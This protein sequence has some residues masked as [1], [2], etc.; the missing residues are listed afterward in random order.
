MAINMH[1]YFTSFHIQYIHIWSIPVPPP[2]MPLTTRIIPLLGDRE[3]RFLNLQGCDWHPGWE[4]GR[5]QSIHYRFSCSMVQKKSTLQE[6]NISPKN[7]ILK[8][9]F[10]TSRLVGYV[11]ISWRVNRLKRWFTMVESV[12]QIASDE[13]KMIDRTQHV[14]QKENT[15]H[16][17]PVDNVVI[18]LPTQTMHH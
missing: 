11:S 6:T 4:G 15:C 10:Q 1:Q 3:S 9:I 14:L 13:S 12:K 7:G 8:M 18:I 2:R 16:L 17:K 5:P